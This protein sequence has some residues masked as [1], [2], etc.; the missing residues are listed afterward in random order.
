MEL[1]FVGGIHGVGKSTV[2]RDLAPRL[3][4][5]HVTASD[6][7]RR[8]ASL[9]VTTDKAVIDVDANQQR[10]VHALVDLRKDHSRIVLD[11]HFCVL[12]ANHSPTTIPLTVFKAIH[13]IGLA[14]VTGELRLIQTRLNDRDGTGYSIGSLEAFQLKEIDHAAFVAR[15][16][17]LPLLV[18]D[19]EHAA[20]ELE[21]FFLRILDEE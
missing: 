4:A 20:I 13:P 12:Q 3:R 8:Q 18:T 16:M 11:G 17:N 9:P 6:L 5:R 10:L 15:S 21:R 19:A 7:I 14:V 1:V 2:C